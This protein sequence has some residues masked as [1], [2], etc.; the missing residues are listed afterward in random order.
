MKQHEIDKLI[1]RYLNREASEEDLQKLDFL[2]RNEA[3]QKKFNTFFK[4]HYL[5]SFS[6]DHF[7]LEKGKAAVR[8]K[9]KVKPRP[10][11]MAL[12]IAAAL[13]LA[14]FV[15]DYFF[16]R[17]PK[18]EMGSPSTSITDHSNIQTGTDK[19]ILTL[20]DGNEVVLSKGQTL[21]LKNMVSNG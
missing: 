21:Q 20:E 1:V 13:V 14:L 5:A 7:D 15:A 2:I 3:H 17:G 12:K 10:R 11:F 19:A 16:S 9:L 6:E 18:N 8:S 4:T